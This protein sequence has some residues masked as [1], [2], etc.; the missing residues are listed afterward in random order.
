MHSWIKYILKVLSAQNSSLSD[1]PAHFAPVR[2]RV[3]CW[4]VCPCPVLRGFCWWLGADSRGQEGYLV[5]L[6][7]LQIRPVYCIDLQTEESD[8]NIL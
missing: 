2:P 7:M 1:L 6:Q 5:T 4:A 3:G 8:Q